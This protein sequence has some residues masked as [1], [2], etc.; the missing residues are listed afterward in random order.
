MLAMRPKEKIQGSEIR[1]VN[2]IKQDPG[3]P[4]RTFKELE[5]ISP[6]LIQTNILLHACTWNIFGTM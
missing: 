6:N 1:Y 2:L 3:G 4:G 5:E